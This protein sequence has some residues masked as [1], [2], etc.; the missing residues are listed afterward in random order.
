MRSWI[1]SVGPWLWVVPAI[2]SCGFMA[3]FN[4][5][6][7]C[8]EVIAMVNKNQSTLKTF[9]ISKD[10]PRKLATS[11]RSMGGVEKQLASDLTGK[12]LKTPELKQISKDYVDFATST[13]QA[14]DDFAKIVDESADIQDQFDT[15]KPTSSTSKVIAS[16]DKLGTTCKVAKSGC[17]DAMKA[18]AKI[19]KSVTDLDAYGTSI[20]RVASDLGAVS[21][22]D[23]AVR[24][25]CDDLKAQLNE[26][27]KYYHQLAALQTKVKTTKAS[28]DTTLAREK[29]LT[30]SLN[31]FCNR[32]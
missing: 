7:E 29:P 9:D 14:T 24:A 27:A 19:P 10:D 5:G 25:A 32:K 23:P 28:L 16:I 12:Q 11:L 17:G 20:E 3:G 2:A 15:K 6:K 18:I 26:N 4:K 21:T 1:R 22:K 30:D 8:V 13:A 31:T